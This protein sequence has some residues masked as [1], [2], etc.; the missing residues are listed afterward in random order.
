VTSNFK[1]RDESHRLVWVTGASS[2]IGQALSREF[3]K[4]G[5]SVILSGRNEAALQVLHEAIKVG[6]GTSHVVVCDVR[7][8]SSVHA[9]VKT[10]LASIGIPDI[11]INNAG[12][13]VF[14]KFLE[15]TTKEFD[16]I[17]D[18]NLRG[19]FLTTKALLPSMVKRKSGIVLNI[20]SFAAKTTYTESSAY[21]ASKAGLASMMEGL[22][23][24]VRDKGVKIVNVFPG[25]VLTPIWHPKVRAKHGRVMISA[26]EVAKMIFAVSC[27]SKSLMV[28]EIVIRPQFGDVD[29]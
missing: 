4:N 18:T 2:G 14:K 11:L 5:Y 23:A 28:E 27:Q 3:G 17:I 10:I 22:R 26:E 12:V 1:T 19:P 20:V 13:T 24:E 8:E 25:A 21:A 9:A 7:K 16:D 29:A 6:R 15:T